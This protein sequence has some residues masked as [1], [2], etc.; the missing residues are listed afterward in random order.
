MKFVS[1]FLIITLFC[2]NLKAQES[3]E[4]RLS[5]LENIVSKLPR[6]MG[7]VN[8]RYR[9]DD[10]DDANSFDVRRVRLDFRGNVAEAWSYRLHFDFASAPNNPPKILDV[11]IN[12]KI[13]DYVALQAGQYKIPFSLENSYNPNNLEMIDNSLAISRLVGYSDVS[14]INANGRDIG[15]GFIGSFF[16]KEG[17]NLLNYSVGI[18]NG[19]GIN[20]AGDTNRNKDFSGTISVNPVRYLTLALS[21]YNGMAGD[22]DNTFQRLRSGFGVKYDDNRLLVRSEYIHGKTSDFK[23]EGAYSVFGYY[24]HPKFQPVARYDYFKRDLSDKNTLQQNHT[25]GFNY[26]P[27]NNVRLQF[28]Y[29][30]RTAHE[31]DSNYIVT[32]LWVKF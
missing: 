22:K 1:I 9:Y 21:H 26:F 20:T 27:A 4:Q 16:K 5:N 13:N 14:G 18:F 23:S 19:S 29:T 12:W 17:Y 3:T 2:L 32:Q 11:F 15:V 28:N 25:V 24:V 30:Y 6:I 7:D 8:L 31:S 10:T